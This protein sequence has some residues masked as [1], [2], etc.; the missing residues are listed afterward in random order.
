MNGLAGHAVVPMTTVSGS[1]VGSIP[2]GASYVVCQW[3]VG[4]KA[5]VVTACPRPLR[6][7][8]GS[9]MSDADAALYWDTYELGN[10]FGGHLRLVEERMSE[11][12]C[13]WASGKDGFSCWAPYQ[14]Q[15]NIEW[16]WSAHPTENDSHA[17]AAACNEIEAW[18]VE[19]RD[20]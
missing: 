20:D 1:R 4:R 12:R 19:S 13:R 8:A 11:P 16:R 7:R 15:G 10:A 5:S 2:N 17:V 14:V 18:L 3:A 9:P 6:R